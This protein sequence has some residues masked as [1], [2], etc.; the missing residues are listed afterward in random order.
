MVVGESG[1]RDYE[2]STTYCD[3]FDGEPALTGRGVDLDYIGYDDHYFLK[4]VQPLEKKL[5]Y[6]IF[7]QDAAHVRDGCPLVTMLYQPNGLVEPGKT[8]TLK[9]R[10]YFGPKRLDALT[11]FSEDM[12]SS[13]YLGW[14]GAIAR[15]LL[16]AVKGI[17]GLLGNYGLAII[18]ITVL[19]K[20]LFFP[21]TRAAQVSMKKM[22]KLQPQMNKIKEKYKDD[23]QRQQQ[24]IMKFMSQNKINPAKGCLPILPQIPVFIAFYNVLSN[25]IELR[26]A[27]FFGWIQDLSQSDPYLITPLLL[28]VGMFLQ[29][30]LTPHP[31]MDKAQERIMMMM[32]VVFTVMMLSLPAGMVLYMLVNTIVSIVQQQWLNKSLA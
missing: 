10:A 29:Q 3:D 1:E 13:L 31:G 15:P 11:A 24:E 30:K 16:W 4:V 23:R 5:T 19:L 18:I 21:L 8:I 20:I 2:D 17:Y 6:S 12:K 7:K 22:Q 27:P 14:F 28:G 25:A 32:P 9:Y 26:H